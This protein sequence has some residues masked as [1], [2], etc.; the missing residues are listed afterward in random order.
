MK[1][2]LW[3]AVNKDG[4]GNI[5]TSL[6]VRNEHFGV[7]EGTMESCFSNVVESLAAEGLPLPNITYNIEPQKISLT[8]DL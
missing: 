4:R 1:K 2:E 3:Y 6:P 8:I 5:F 7:W